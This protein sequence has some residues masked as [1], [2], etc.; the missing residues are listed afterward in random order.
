M[1][2]GTN[3]VG[4][5]TGDGIQQ[6]DYMGQR[7]IYGW[8]YHDLIYTGKEAQIKYAE[9]L[10][11]AEL[12]KH[13]VENAKAFSEYLK[14]MGVWDDKKNTPDHIAGVRERLLSVNLNVFGFWQTG[15]SATRR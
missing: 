4:S 7:D 5:I 12:A 8:E 9:A 13:K 1:V 2:V 14:S 11:E 15:W 6:A 10:S 3:A